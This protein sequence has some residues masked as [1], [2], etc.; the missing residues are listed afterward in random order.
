MMKEKKRYIVYYSEWA[1][2]GWY[3]TVHEFEAE[4]EPKA[5]IKALME[6]VP[7]YYVNPDLKIR[8]IGNSW[9]G[10]ELMKLAGLEVRNGEVVEKEGS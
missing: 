7:L 9:T 2:P 3:D 5:I 1:S 4:P 8:E 10:K 6:V